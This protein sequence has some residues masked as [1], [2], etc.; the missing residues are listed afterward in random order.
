MGDTTGPWRRPLVKEI[1]ENTL[2]REKMFVSHLSSILCL[3]FS[4]PSLSA[5]F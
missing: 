2:N 5:T 3:F 4:L 1:F